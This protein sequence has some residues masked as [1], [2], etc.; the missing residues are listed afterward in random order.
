ME[1][2]MQ[3]DGSKLTIGIEGYLDAVTTPEFE[4]VLEDN[5]EG[6]TEL[7]L[8]LAKLEYLSSAGLRAVLYA[9]K[10]MNEQGTMT[11][12]N[13]SQ[14][15]LDIFVVTGFDGILTFG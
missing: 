6:V 2:S 3:R 11:V 8:D 15:V 4:S 13:A 1:I 7:T 14:D 10:V 12:V 9:Q 5:L